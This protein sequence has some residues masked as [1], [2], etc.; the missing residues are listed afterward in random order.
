MGLKETVLMSVSA[1]IMVAPLLAYIF[2]TF[3][4]VSI[5]ANLLVLPVMPYVMFFG[6]LTGLGGLIFDS[7][8]RAVGL[9]AWMLSS[10]QLHVIQWLGALPF[11]AVT[12]VMSSIVLG[13][14]YALIIFGIWSVKVIKGQSNG[15]N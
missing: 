13:L 1:Q 14:L 15:N 2:H 10:Y 3:S 5:P 12:V 8:G 7:L 4:L 11:S 9:V 6:F